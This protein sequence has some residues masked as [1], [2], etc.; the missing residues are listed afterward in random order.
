MRVALDATPLTLSSG[1]L[2]RYVRELHR[3]LEAAFPK[4]EFPLLAR[5][6]APRGF[7]ERRWWLCGLTR[8]LARRRVEIFHGTN[9]EVPYL[10]LRPSVLTLHD[11]SPWMEP[12]WHSEADRVRRRTPYLVGLGLATMV[13]T[14]SQA[15]RRQAIE[16]FRISPQRVVAV[17]E[18]AAPHLR[19]APAP[20]SEPYF[21]FLATLEPRKNI[22]LLLEAWREARRRAPVDLVLAGRRREDF[23]ALPEE[24]GLTVLGEIAEDRLSAW[25]SGALAFVY[26][27]LYEGFGLPVVEAMQ[28]GAAVI[29]SRDPAISEVAAGAAVQV[30]ARDARGW[31]EALVAAATRPEWIAAL[32]AKS[33][34]RSRDFSWERT[35]RLTR[36]VYQEALG[37]F[38]AA[39]W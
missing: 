35:A 28:C 36:E 11:L 27:S 17:P 33:L 3:A 5:P 16:R 31:T 7:C 25:Y 15:V 19:P 12:E 39:G 1:G 26:P 9:F 21:L 6:P 24:P 29:A 8:E 20:H 13:V 10:P 4:D 37:R 38:G 2:A 18:A 32:R 22:R 14:P 23:P 30:D 34:E